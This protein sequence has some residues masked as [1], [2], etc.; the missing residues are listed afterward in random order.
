METRWSLGATVLAVL[1]ICAAASAARAAGP[2]NNVEWNGISH[3]W[4]QDRRPLCPLAGESFEV[5]FQTYSNDITSARVHVDDGDVAWIEAVQT[6]ARGPYDVWAAQVPSTPSATLSYYIELTDGSD[7]DYMSASGMSNGAP[8]DGGFVLDFTTLA[9]A[10]AGATPVPGGGAVFRVWAPTRTTVYVRGE[11]NGWGTTNPL[12]KVGEHFI[13]Y[14]PSAEDRDMYKY[15]F[16]GSVWNTDARARSLNPSENYNAHIEDRFRYDWQVEDFNTPDFEEMIVYQLHV[17]TFAGRNDPY[18]S[19]PFPSRYVDVAARAS[20]LAELGINAVMLNPITEFPGDLSAGYN[21]LTEWAPEWKYGTP[22]DL[23]YMVDELHSYGIAVILDIVWNHFS[24]D[25]NFLWYYDGTQ[26]YFDDPAVETPWGSQAD[27]DRDEVREYFANSS[28]MWLE[29]FQIDG[30]RMDATSYMNIYPQ[31]ASGWSLMQRLNDE[32]DNRWADKISIA[33]QLPDDSWVTRPTSLGGAGFDSQYQ[34]VFTDRLRE[35]IIDAALGDP[36]MWKIA[37]IVNGSG[38]YMS[39]RFVTNYLELHDEA[40]PSSGG[41]RMV[42][43]IDTTYPHDDEYAKGRIKLAQGVVMGTPGIPAVLMGTEWL[44]DTDFGTDTGNR[45]DWS[46]KTTYAPIF[47]YFQDLILLRKVNPALR[48]DAGNQVFHVNESGNVVAFQRWGGSGDVLVVIANFSNTDYGSYRVGLPQ[49]GDWLEALNSQATEYDGNGITNPGVI[50]TE[51]IAQDGFSQS[52]A[53]ALPGMGF[54][55]LSLGPPTSVPE[56]I[57][58]VDSP[59]VVGAYPNP[60]NPRTTIA[61]HFPEPGRGGLTI[62][63]VSGRLVRRLAERAFPAGLSQV[64][65]EGTDNAGRSL[66]SGV[67]FVL[68]STERG[69]SAEKLV[70]LR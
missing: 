24:F 14:V 30:F 35:E 22:D 18:G 27:F 49:P 60:S 50:A 66:P 25:D 2:D 29:E 37:D 62:H 16:D 9:H 64:T 58:P 61:V 55:I 17:G 31:Q 52:A 15:F 28:L 59:R 1:A 21:P 43:T 32:M 51:A 57:Q 48:A 8:V 12:S 42:K 10:P 26:I 23:R 47:K 56:D 4:W 44:E 41:Q 19:T 3:V 36:E 70:L 63:D 13:A 34:D 39:G 5:R 67:Y 53:I 6:A 65:W 11:F 45:I 54:I 68:L 40:W 20:H 33:E 7:T 46:K 38:E 69:S